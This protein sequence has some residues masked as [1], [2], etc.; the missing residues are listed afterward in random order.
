MSGPGLL[1]ILMVTRETAAE[2]RYGLGKSLQPVVDALRERGHEVRYLSQTDLGPRSVNLRERIHRWQQAAERRGRHAHADVLRWL[3]ALFERINMGR[4]ASQVAAREGFGIVHC[5]DPLIALGFRLFR[6]WRPAAWGAYWGITEHGFGSYAQAMQDDGV[7]MR[8]GFMRMLR[9][10]EANVLQAA[11]WVVAPTASALSA[12]ARDL[13]LTRLPAHWYVVPHARPV[14]QRRDRLAA[15][16]ILG[17]QDD[18]FYVVGVGRLVPLKQF[19]VFVRACARVDAAVPL[20]V[21]ILGEGDGQRL[22]TLGQDAGLGNPIEFAVTDDVGLYL[23]AADVYVS[24][25][26]SEAFGMAN[27]EALTAGLPSVCSPVGGVPDVVGAGAWLVPPTIEAVA[28]ALTK[29]AGDP[30]SRVYWA[31]SAKAHADAWPDAV[32]VAERYETIYRLGMAG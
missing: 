32:Q 25:S 19:E 6:I 30:A 12:L 16:H 5:H 8:R 11:N 13:S 23:S 4:L 31:R 9:A 21:V 28:Q 24:T 7:P 22:Q 27:L 26:A 1:R 17:W 3:W 10:V 29:L 14:L 2:R 18:G 15:R 20:R